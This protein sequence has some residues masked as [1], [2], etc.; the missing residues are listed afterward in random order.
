MRE[1]PVIGIT[2]GI[3]SGKSTVARAFGEVGCEVIDADALGHALLDEPGIREAIRR[4]WGG[5]VVNA[6]GAVDR[7]KLG[8]LVFADPQVRRRLE[9]ILHPPMRSEMQRRIA[10]ARQAGRTRA[11]VIDAAVLFE[12]GWDVLCT[13]T[14][15]V[16]APL[17]DRVARVTAAR[18]WSRAELLRREKVQF[19]L[20]RKQELCCYGLKNVDDVSHLP[21]QVTRLLDDILE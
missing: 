17:A 14:V 6:S 12:A 19:P 1:I 7:G 15:Y 18:G 20:D 3:G 10:A 5:E 8:R 9:D 21:G 2:G 4:Q 16:E 13:H 11:V